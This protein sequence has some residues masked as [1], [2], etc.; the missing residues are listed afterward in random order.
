M[1]KLILG[2]VAQEHRRHDARIARFFVCLFAA[3]AAFTAA[4]PALSSASTGSITNAVYAADGLHLSFDASFAVDACGE[5]SCYWSTVLMSQPEERPC[6]EWE[7]LSVD[8]VVRFAWSGTAHR[9]DATD[10]LHVDRALNAVGFTGSR[11][12]LYAVGSR[13]TP[14]ESSDKPACQVGACP[15]IRHDFS[16]LI[17]TTVATIEPSPPTPAESSSPEPSPPPTSPRRCR[18]GFHRKVVAGKARCVKKQRHRSRTRHT[19]R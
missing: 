9:T 12:C 15:P 13:Y 10:S 1:T 14:A 19:R 7:F 11:L 6:E 3:A 4:S 17:G 2:S 5:D 16:D 8:P 18:K